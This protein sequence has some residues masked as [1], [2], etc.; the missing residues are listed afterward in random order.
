[1]LERNILDVPTCRACSESRNPG[2]CEAHTDRK[3]MGCSTPMLQPN[4][5]KRGA[6]NRARHDYEGRCGVTPASTQSLSLVHHRAG[7]GTLGDKDTGG[8]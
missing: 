2:K 3:V 4:T 6:S 7:N 8:R 1:M 5:P